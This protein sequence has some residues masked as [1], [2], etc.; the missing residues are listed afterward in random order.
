MPWIYKITAIWGGMDGSMLFW[1][2]ILSLSGSI[3]AY[4]SRHYSEALQ[5]NF[6]PYVLAVINSSIL[7]FLTVVVFETNPF[8]YIK[9]DFIP[10][11]GNGLNPL[12]Q[13]PYMA[14]HPP[15]LYLGFTTFGIPFAYCIGALLSNNLTNDWIQLTRKWILV[16]W[17]FLT[18]GITLGGFWAYIEL[19][20]GGFWAWDPVENAS[21]HP[22][23]TATAFLH[24]V[25]VQDRKNMLKTWNIW[26][27]VLTYGLTVFG[28]FLTRSGVVTSVHAFANSDVGITFLI[29]LGLIFITTAV[30]VWKRRE[31]LRS[32]K[33]IES[34]FSREAVFLLN[35]LIL[36]CICFSIIWGVLF[37]IISEAFTGK[38]QTIGVP[39]FNAVNIPL[40]LLL[41]F[42]MGLGPLI[43]WRKGNYSLFKKTALLPFLCAMFLGVVL[44]L[45]GV[46]TF[47]STL[48]YSL[49]WFVFITII[50]E[51]RK[52]LRNQ[53]SS[54]SNPSKAISS[55]VA[56]LV[57]RHRTR[58]GG[59]LVHLGVVIAVIGIT[60]S[61]THKTEKEFTLSINETFSLGKFDFKLLSLNEIDKPNY[62]GLEAKISL[63]QSTS[64]KELA[65]LV[66]ELRFYPRNKETTSEV[67]LKV[68]ILE[69]VYLVLGGLDD[70]GTKA[71]FK[72]FIN[73]LQIWLWIGVGLISFATLFIVIPA[74]FRSSEPSREKVLISQKEVVEV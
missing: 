74:Y 72:L 53:R 11:D 71:S 30:L 69:D 16:S 31:V 22:W 5:R 12:L 9:A 52:G 4:S 14:I 67:A 51:F 42:L 36:L 48:S 10:P 17:L 68:G 28:T 25:M 66:P 18:I 27:V 38:K 46:G 59:L 64:K 34:F 73:P 56:R 29:Y 45:T 58:Y 43:P 35:N 47:Y 62:Q 1:A 15:M 2:L 21:F 41:I 26:L 39:Y 60:A 23:L 49:C 50:G 32:D 57:R 55:E 13:N 44:T 24:S 61:M 65:T 8:R 7:F 19:G 37:P 20:W 54:S 63:Q 40:F 33:N 70:T 6:M 3:A